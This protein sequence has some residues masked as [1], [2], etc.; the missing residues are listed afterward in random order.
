MNKYSLLSLQVTRIEGHPMAAL[1]RKFATSYQHQ[2]FSFLCTVDLLLI[3][4]ELLHH[5]G[6]DA[7]S[8]GSKPPPT[9][10]SLFGRVTLHDLTCTSCNT[11]RYR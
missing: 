6:I 8:N 2:I 3:S 1:F 4:K 5:A 10:V 9:L 11:M 7:S